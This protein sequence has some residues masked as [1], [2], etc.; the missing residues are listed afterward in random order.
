MHLPIPP[1]EDP[2]GPDPAIPDHHRSPHDPV[3]P[4][5]EPVFPQVDPPW[6]ARGGD[7]PRDR[8]MIVA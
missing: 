7:E 4:D 6:P 5:Q 8:P 1:E 2:T 3:P